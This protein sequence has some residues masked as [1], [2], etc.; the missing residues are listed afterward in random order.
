MRK[1]V[2]SLLVALAVAAIPMLASSQARV[3]D[4]DGNPVAQPRY[5]GRPPEPARIFSVSINDEAGKRVASS[6]MAALP[7]LGY[8]FIDSR[9]DSWLI[10]DG[11]IEGEARGQ[12]TL[13]AVKVTLQVRRGLVKPATRPS[14]RADKG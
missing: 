4:Q 2:F 9:G 14:N 5:A 3:V 10:V 11:F 1:I 6:Q 7:P 8:H 13:Q 12:G